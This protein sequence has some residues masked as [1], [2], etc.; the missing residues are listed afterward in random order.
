[1]LVP[2]TTN[3][4][5]ILQKL[6]RI[7]DRRKKKEKSEPRSHQ[8]FTGEHKKEGIIAFRARMRIN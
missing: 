4:K 8:A 7:E 2:C 3:K 5:Y 1:M 6:I